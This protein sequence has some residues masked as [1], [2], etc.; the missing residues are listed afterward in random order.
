MGKLVKAS[1]LTA[2]LA[3][4]ALA[5]EAVSRST[6]ASVL[7]TVTGANAY[8]TNANSPYWAYNSVWGTPPGTS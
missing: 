2:L 6:R 4:S 7:S 1:M 3:G 5:D 8:Y